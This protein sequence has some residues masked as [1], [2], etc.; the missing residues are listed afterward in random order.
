MGRLVQVSPANVRHGILR[1]GG[2]LTWEDTSPDPW[3]APKELKAIVQ[4]YDISQYWYALT[5]RFEDP[6]ENVWGVEP[7]RFEG[8]YMDLMEEVFAFDFEFAVTS[9]P[10]VLKGPCG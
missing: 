4:G 10:T 7:I 9:A 2:V 1:G 3:I 5:K 6:Y 8:D